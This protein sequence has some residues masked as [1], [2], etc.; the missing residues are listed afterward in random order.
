MV[1]AD[2]VAEPATTPAGADARANTYVDPS[3]LMRYGR[4]T[5]PGPSRSFQ[6]PQLARTVSIIYTGRSCLGRFRYQSLSITYLLHFVFFLGAALA[7]KFKASQL[8]KQLPT[9]MKQ[10]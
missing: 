3:R 9:G 4:S 10:I 1:S 6:L 7:I 5:A 2:A 8:W